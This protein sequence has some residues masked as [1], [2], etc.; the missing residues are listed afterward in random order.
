MNNEYISFRHL[1]K[2]FQ[3]DLVLKDISAVL[4]RGEI[5]VFL[6]LAV[7]GRPQPSNPDRTA[8]PYFRGSQSAWKTLSGH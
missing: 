1:S 4:H 7:L 3:N 8:S 2:K 5:L 6:A